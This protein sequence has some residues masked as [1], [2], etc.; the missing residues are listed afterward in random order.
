MDATSSNSCF[1]TEHIIA[2]LQSTSS[3][4][5]L[6]MNK[7]FLDLTHTLSTQKR[8][9]TFC[10]SFATELDFILSRKPTRGM[11]ET[12]TRALARVCDI[13]NFKKYDVDAKKVLQVC[14]HIKGW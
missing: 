10:F 2:T 14:K 7:H 4:F 11:G 5:K 9:V 1:E 8:N 3:S 12:V 6:E 13:H